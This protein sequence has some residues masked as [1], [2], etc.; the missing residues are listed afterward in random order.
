MEELV[1]K[2]SD[3][4]K[5]KRELKEFSQNEP[6]EWS[7]PAVEV[8][9]G[10][11]GWGDHK[12][13]GAEL[14]ERVEEVQKHLQYLN[15]TSIKT[16]KEF[17]NIYKALD[18]LDKSYINVLL[19]EMEQ[20][21]KVSNGVKTNQEYIK[22]IV[23][24]QKKTLEVLKIFK[25]KLDT[26]AHLEDIDKLWNDCQTWKEEIPELSDLVRHV[27]LT[28]NSNSGQIEEIGK[29]IQCHKELLFTAVAETAEKNEA[30]AREL[31]KKIKYAYLIAGSS[32]GVAL[33][34]LIIMLSKV[35]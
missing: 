7:L 21:R 11:L 23:E 20:I 5:A 19:G 25:Q 9:G 3:F 12:V 26:Y 22:K 16:V 29:D 17:E 8:T 10:I 1:I 6:G 4:E 32:L 34:E 24:D 28:S 14:N 27:M 33:A 30:T 35:L 15:R 13:T 18:E 2:R 31:T